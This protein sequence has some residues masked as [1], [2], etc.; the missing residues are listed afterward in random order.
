MKKRERVAEEGQK[1]EREGEKCPELFEQHTRAGGYNWQLA[2]VCSPIFRP[3]GRGR[4]RI[5]CR[6]KQKRAMEFSVEKGG[7]VGKEEERGRR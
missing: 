5:G 1:K 3:G 4:G 2:Y 6:R 7:G